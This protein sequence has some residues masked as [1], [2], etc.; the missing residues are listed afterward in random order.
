MRTTTLL[1][2]TAPVL[3]ALLAGC[4]GAP[5]DAGF[6]E[7]I[8]AS[9]QRTGYNVTWTRGADE[10]ARVNDATTDLLSQELTL[11]AAVKVA[12][13]NNRGLQATFENLGV[14]RGE[15]V[16]A[17]LIANP[18]FGYDLWLYDGGLTFEGLLSED[19]TSILYQ[20]LRVGYRRGQF[21]ATKRLVTAQVVGLV[22]DLRRA[23]FNYQADKQLVAVFEQVVRATEASYLVAA[24]MREAGGMRQ[25][26]V[27]QER[28]LYEQAKLALNAAVE[29]LATSREAMNTLMGLWGDQLSWQTPARLPDVP[30]GEAIVTTEADPTEAVTPREYPS[31]FPPMERK[32]NPQGV[33]IDAE[34][35]MKMKGMSPPP[36][37]PEAR[38]EGL[39]GGPTTRDIDAPPPDVLGG[40][41]D[42]MPATTPAHPAAPATRPGVA[43]EARFAGVER[44]AVARNLDLAAS[45]RLIEAQASRLKLNVALALVPFADAGFDSQ[46]EVGSGKWGVGPGGAVK[47]PVFDQGQGVYPREASLLR[48]RVEQYAFL[49]TGVRA[50]ARAAE[51]RLQ[52]T[53]ARAAYYRDVILPLR[54]AV[55]AESQL[56]YNAMQLGQFELLVNKRL[57][58]QAGQEYVLALRDYWRARADLEQILDGSVPPG[59]LAGGGGAVSM[60]AAGAGGA[61]L[62]GG[63]NN[64]NMN[65]GGN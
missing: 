5:R 45:R 4:A 32:V 44:A 47:V 65:M 41:L 57:Q 12:L 54:A 51:A 6:S 38:A 26:D 31:K 42:L 30:A 39:A 63:M 35:G 43:S 1:L 17:G 27:L 53:R 24:R 64:A 13:L 7:V 21:E 46:K 60:G 58:I 52:T 14:A 48:Q 3:A 23:Y 36:A 61:N 37:T 2:A 10:D 59:V 11:D 22:G 19:L 56:Q 50:A 16:N 49:A 28:A 40:D 18:V 8:D 55:T 29:R 15:L 34:P 25:L 33:P 62:M 9:R 20:P